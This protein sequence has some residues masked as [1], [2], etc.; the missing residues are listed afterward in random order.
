M[1]AKR[2][3]FVAVVKAAEGSL[4]A[5]RVEHVFVGALA[6]A[7]FGVPRTTTDVDVIVDYRE[8]DA[9]RLAESFRRRSFQVSAE[10]L[11]DARAEGAHC[12]V[13]DTL[14]AFCVHIAPAARPRT[15]DAIRHSVR[16]RWRG[17]TLPIADPEHTIVMKLVYGSDQDVEDALGIFVR[18]RR[19][20]KVRRMRE[21]AGRQGA[22][23]ALREL[24]RRAGG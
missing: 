3:S 12:T 15:K 2:R 1:P 5:A 18:Q 13:H 17:S 14:S 7:A 23:K 4:R 9:P 8:E 6:V 10:D 20:L 24:E 19:R 16:V 11:R 22:L 21:F